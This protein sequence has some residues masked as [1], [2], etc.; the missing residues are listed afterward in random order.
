MHDAVLEC[1]QSKLKCVIF[2]RKMKSSSNHQAGRAV[3]TPANSGYPKYV[4]ML[5]VS[6]SVPTHPTQT[7]GQRLNGSI[8][9]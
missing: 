6:T 3:R 7:P 5:V 8:H 2:S 1:V 9:A 4:P